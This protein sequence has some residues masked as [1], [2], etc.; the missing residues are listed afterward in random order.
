MLISILIE[1]IKEFLSPFAIFL[2]SIYLSLLFQQLFPTNE[3]LI[4]LFLFLLTISVL[5]QPAISAILDMKKYTGAILHLFFTMY[6]LLSASLLSSG[7]FVSFSLWQPTLFL[8]IQIALFVSNAILLPFLVV[9]ILLDFM[10]RLQPDLSF[11]KFTDLMRLSLLS[12]VSIIVFLYSFFI[13]MSGMVQS[14]I[15]PVFSVPIKKW[16]Q[17]NIPFVGS[18]LTEGLSTFTSISQHISSLTGLT[19]TGI[20][21]T[22]ILLPSVKIAL[23]AFCYRFIAAIIEPFAPDDLPDFVDD[24]GRTLFSLLLIS[25]LFVF[26][27]FYTV[28]F[29]VFYMKW[30]AIMRGMG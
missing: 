14:S 18:A 28:M 7:E 17:Q 27:L 9:T 12:G 29:V 3:K 5:C 2:V 22:A 23:L 15:S 25:L 4:R 8:F 1:L 13:G 20:L 11:T 26:A 19:L 6:P 21:V 16:I 30:V 10:S 24:I